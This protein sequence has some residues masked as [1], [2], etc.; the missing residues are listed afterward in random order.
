MTERQDF[1]SMSMPPIFIN[2][3]DEAFYQN[4]DTITILTN[5]L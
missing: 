3:S 4:L 2:K 5:I 1:I